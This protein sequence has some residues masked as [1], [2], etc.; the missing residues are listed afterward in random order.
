MHMAHF[1]DYY[2][3]MGLKRD[4]PADDIKR[5]YRKLARKYHPDVSDKP[6][7]EARFKELGEAYEVLKDPEKRAAY[8]ELGANWQA[9]Q[10]FRPPPDWGQQFGQRGDFTAADGAQFSDFF[11]SLF[12]DADPRRGSTGHSA[13]G[14]DT[15]AT[16]RIALQDVYTGATRSVTLRHAELDVHG[17][18]QPKS[19]T[20]SV[21]IPKG[22]REGQHIRLSGQGGPGMGRGASGDLLLEVEFEPHK[23]FQVDGVDVMLDLPVAPWEA[24]LGATVDVP[25]PAGPVSLKIPAGS[26]GG[27][28]LR[29]RGRG[30]P[31]KQ[32]GDLYVTL[33]IALPPAD[34]D[35]AKAAYR[36]LQKAQAFD[37]RAGM[38]V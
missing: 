14:D 26:S 38:V 1:R 13:R 12:G 36:D 33:R 18:P 24:A 3:T 23:V 22:I 10:D 7:A 31:S 37:P 19:R 15:R 29:L 32:P 2:E 4:A 5:A 9:G 34:T 25:T 21:R 35:A 30:I 27:R 28:K 11:R 20:L 16:V 6:D 17:R 8:D